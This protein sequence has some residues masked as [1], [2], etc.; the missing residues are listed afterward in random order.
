MKTSVCGILDF[1]T[2]RSRPFAFFLLLLQSQNPDLLLLLNCYQDVM[3]IWLDF[4]QI[5]NIDIGGSYSS[6]SIKQTEIVKQITL[7]LSFPPSQSASPSG[8]F[9]LSDQAATVCPI[10]EALSVWA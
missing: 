3:V 1:E 9:L 2:K 8:P 10:I 4:L 6:Q 5:D 7:S